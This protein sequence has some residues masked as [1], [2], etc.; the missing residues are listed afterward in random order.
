MKYLAA[1]ALVAFG[2][3]AQSYGP[4]P[5]YQAGLA[6]PVS[7]VAARSGEKTA[8]LE[9]A[10]PRKIVYTA[11]VDLVV[12]QF[13]PIPAKV[14]AL[15]EQFDGYVARSDLRG[16]SGRPR[17]GNWTIRVP[18]EHYREFLAAA[19]ELGEVR[20]L[21]SDSEDVSEEYYD[22][23]A[24]IRNKKKTEDRLLGQLEDATGSL[25]DILAVEEKLDRVREEIERMQ[26]RKRVLDDLTSMTTVDLSV[27]EVEN[28]SPDRS[29]TYG[30]RVRRALNT[31]IA[32][33]VDTVQATSIAV[34]FLL[35]W[36]GV[37]LVS[38]LVGGL[39]LLGLWRAFGFA[40]RRLLPVAQAVPDTLNG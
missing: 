4:E 30:T 23:E 10:L 22:V 16:A 39:G 37:L 3:S 38:L 34:V 36:L 27:D 1:L 31:S 32:N 21:N 24:R 19:V 28:Y 2:C 5:E 18:V 26:G 29:A 33:L 17:S 15:A 14:E 25:E 7:A 8:T 12:D 35:P 13:D 11:T 20:S 9:N 40:R 6:E